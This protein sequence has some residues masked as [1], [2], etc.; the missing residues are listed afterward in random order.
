MTRHVCIVCG[1]VYD[2]AQGDPVGRIPPGTTF[3]DL[4]EHWSCPE[5]GAQKEMFEAR[6]ES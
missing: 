2:P 3:E 1:Y 6:E 4:P 5:C